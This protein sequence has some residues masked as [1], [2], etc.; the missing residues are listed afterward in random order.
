MRSGN[1]IKR[2]GRLCESEI[3][4]TILQAKDPIDN[5]TTILYEI[6]EKTI[7]KT[8]TKIKKKK[9]PWFI[10]DCKTSIKKGDKLYD[11]LILVQ[12]IKI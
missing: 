11:N 2:I 6:P 12:Y 3:N 1:Q 8:S 4:E 9:K 5:F 10:A 7:P